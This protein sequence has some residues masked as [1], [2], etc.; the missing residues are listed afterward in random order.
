M[1]VTTNKVIDTLTGENAKRAL[2]VNVMRQEVRELAQRGATKALINGRVR[3]VIV[4]EQRM[5]STVTAIEKC[6]SLRHDAHLNATQELI[7]KSLTSVRRST[8][9]ISAARKAS[10]P[11]E[12]LKETAADLE[13]FS[14]RTQQYQ[15]QMN[16]I[17]EESLGA[18]D[19]ITGGGGAQKEIS[20][21]E[22]ARLDAAFMAICN[23]SDAGASA[24]AA[25]AASTPALLA[26]VR[27]SAVADAA[28][29]DA[30][31]AE[32][33]ARIPRPVAVVAAVGR[34]TSAA[35]ILGAPDAPRD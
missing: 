13:D 9:R 11:H 23:G 12:S 32:F 16:E 17:L 10:N 20:S 26:P 19:Q 6:R 35:D 2:E 8:K 24:A 15:E 4:A 14:S 18:S 7:Q 31:A 3:Q 30:E 5:E 33:V 1:H 28:A 25:A 21:E 27:P 29:A 34:Y 22:Q